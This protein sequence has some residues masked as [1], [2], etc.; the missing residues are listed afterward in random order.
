MVARKIFLDDIP[1]DEARARL[2]LALREGGRW[3]PL[4]GER[5]PL[6]A[7]VGRITADPVWARLSSPH[8]HAA[9]MD[10]Y[11]VRAAETHAA[12]ETRPVQLAIGTHA[13]AVNT[14][15][16]LPAG[17]NAVIM[18][19]QVAEGAAHIEVRASVAPWQH[20]RLMGEDM[21]ATELILPANHR[22]RPVDLGAI[23]GSGHAAVSVRR[24][25]R[26]TII[27]TGNEL[28]SLDPAGTLDPQPAPGQIIEYNSVV[29]RAQVIEAGG[30]AEIAA[31]V[32]DAPD[33]LRHALSQAIST[34][35][36]APDLILVL[37]GSSAGSRDFSAEAIAALGRVL[38][39][40][41]AV[42][43]GHPVIIGLIAGI[44]VIGVPGYPVSAALTGELFVQPILSHWLGLSADEQPRPRLT[45]TLTRKLLSPAGDDDF[46]RVTLAQ[47]GERLLATPLN[48][49]A[50]VVTSLV[51]ADGLAHIPRFSEGVEQGAALEVALYRPLASVQRAVLS[52][53]SHDPMLD[54]LAHHLS[55]AFP[56]ERLTSANVG[57]MGGL[58][59][60]RRDECHVAGIHLLDEATGGYN[61]SY[62]GNHLRSIALQ[63]VTFA[64]REQGLMV[65]AG[66]PLGVTSL[67]DVSRVR[68]V[69]RQRGAGT[70]LLLD[71]ELKRRGID[72]TAISGYELEEYTHLGVA[73]AV[74]AGMADCGM[75]VR[76]AA[77]ALGLDFVPVGWERYDLV[78][79]DAHRDHP[80]V[81]RLLD[82]LRSAVFI[83]ALGA[84]PGYDT[85]ETGKVM[86]RHIPHEGGGNK[87]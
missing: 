63:L 80:G 47:V 26:V 68:Y 45:A 14:G 6:A 5:V 15:D 67:D 28:V 36:I 25:P 48:R 13:V 81:A 72:P 9:A 56:G 39:H 32:P 10:G 55:L 71:Y 18:I 22:L 61:I 42:R 27:P 82:T 31:S 83:A 54:L 70:R 40:G 64:H 34:K 53:G 1:L 66:N 35:A 46:V 24:S 8:Y 4:P 57:S 79:P 76:S 69:N 85:G 33:L 7:A 29:L 51:R 73:A 59:A 84:Q 17:M 78:I 62:V 20:V 11:A 23:A 30:S 41:V 77:I 86:M 43:P 75:G 50:G 19:E 87:H 44:P 16:P 38:V 21:V 65:A 58:V 49:G 60:I 37:S 3:E 52:M 74:A 2:E 12:T